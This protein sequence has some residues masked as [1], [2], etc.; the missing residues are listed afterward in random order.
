MTDTTS[1]FNFS[2]KWFPAEWALL[3]LTLMRINVHYQTFVME[4][5]SFMA[6]QLYNIDTFLELFK[7]NAAFMHFIET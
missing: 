3:T 7:T 4:N 5:M 2:S 6:I 1:V